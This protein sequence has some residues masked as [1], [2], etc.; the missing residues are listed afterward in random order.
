M[1]IIVVLNFSNR[2][3]AS[4][5]S[6]LIHEFPDDMWILIYEFIPNNVI[7]LLN[8]KI[9]NL[10]KF[11]SVRKIINP[12][13]IDDDLLKERST[14]IYNMLIRCERL[15]NKCFSIDMDFRNLKSLTI[16]GSDLVEIT[17]QF[18]DLINTKTTDEVEYN[19]KITKLT[20]IRL[21]I[22]DPKFCGD[23]LKK[24]LKKLSEI[25]S[26][27]RVSL[28]LRRRNIDEQMFKYVME[29][30][31]NDSINTIQF[32][33]VASK[34]AKGALQHLIMLT[35]IKNLSTLLIDTTGAKIP[36]GDILY[37]SQLSLCKNLMILRIAIWGTDQNNSAVIALGNIG[38]M[39]EQYANKMKN[40]SIDVG[41]NAIT[42]AG[43]EPFRKYAIF[44]NVQK[45]TIGLQGL[46]ITQNGI[47]HLLYVKD[48]EYLERLTWYL[49]YCQLE[50]DGME[51]ISGIYNDTKKHTLS[52]ICF[53]IRGNGITDKGMIHLKKLSYINSLR[54]MA[55][56]CTGNS[57]RDGGAI[58]FVDAVKMNLNAPKTSLDLRQNPIEN[59][60][61]V[62][63]K[64]IGFPNITVQVD[65]R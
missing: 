26:L 33:L 5:I 47:R 9:K 58:E 34:F 15:G 17:Y 53:D 23:R 60:R 30:L 40:L 13:N 42:D 63:D 64:T 20:E 22:S 6:R 3:M 8:K 7:R 44:K 32:D 46:P 41:G 38:N 19:N 50:D 51:I 48:F 57:I 25:K 24:S 49:G 11:R 54:S 2:T 45:I 10:V 59:C 65:A 29:S 52:S 62:R 55:L 36:T 28:K 21:D 18:L 27:E 1:Y 39:E 43:I 12:N 31:Q 4:I 56:H 14:F 37:F 61:L 16:E 35:R